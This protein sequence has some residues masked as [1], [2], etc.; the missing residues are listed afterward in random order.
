MVIFYDFYKLSIKLGEEIVL[1]P[2]FTK[3]VSKSHS[4]IFPAFKNIKAKNK[5]TVV[6]ISEKHVFLKTP[7]HS[8][9]F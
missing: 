7:A 2:R 6:S 9:H 4:E 5:E 8:Q 1:R 3:Q